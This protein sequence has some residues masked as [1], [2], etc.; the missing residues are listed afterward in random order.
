MGGDQQRS[1]GPDVRGPGGAAAAGSSRQERIAAALAD[2][3]AETQ[4]QQQA[5]DDKAQKW[6]ATRDERAGRRAGRPPADIE[7]QVITAEPVTI[8][9]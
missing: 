5:A 4:A 1:A 9:V 8:S 7:V 3:R 6:L 2:L